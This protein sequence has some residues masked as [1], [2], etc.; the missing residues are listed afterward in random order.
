MITKSQ[1]NKFKKFLKND[2]V[3]EVLMEL[4]N[5][6]IVSRDNKP[7]SESMLRMVFTGKAENQAIET[8]IMDV[9]L[10]RKQKHEAIEAKKAQILSQ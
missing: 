8:A 9:Y 10:S 6:Q 1:K 3:D 2:W 4:S 7:Y 5:K